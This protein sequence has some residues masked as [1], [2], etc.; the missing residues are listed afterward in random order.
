M[1]IH[2]LGLLACGPVVYLV[3]TLFDYGDV[4]QLALHRMHA[5]VETD[6]RSREP[7]RF[8]F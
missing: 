7:E 8:D 5:P 1:T 6:A 4:R 3:C 2:P